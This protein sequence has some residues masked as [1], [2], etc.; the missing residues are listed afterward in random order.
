MLGAATRGS[1]VGVGSLVRV[2]L[3]RSFPPVARFDARVLVLGS[4][5]GAASLAAGRYYA[6][7]RNAFWPVVG[8]LCG[9]ASD[10]PYERR[11]EALQRAGVALWDVLQSCER[12]G[13]LDGDIE[14]ATARANDFAAFLPQLPY[15][16]LVACNGGTAHRLFCRATA[17][18]PASVVVPT[19]VALPSTS[20]AHAAR[21]SAQKLAAWRAALA[22]FLA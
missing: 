6:H 7:P 8:A 16:Q 9:V 18:L 5:P 14:P 20:P 1:R 17:T 3:V 21:S 2:A 12:D 11:L 22:R 10:A 4:M 13:S 15:L 19:I